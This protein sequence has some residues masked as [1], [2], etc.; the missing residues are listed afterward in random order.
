MNN[1]H[2]VFVIQQP[3]KRDGEGGERPAF[4]F[5]A[6]EG[7]GKLI[8]LAPNGKQIL[9]PDVF[10]DYL[11]GRLRA[12]AF[13]PKTDYIIPAGDYSVILMVG[14]II[15]EMFGRARILRWVPSAS[16]YQ[17]LHFNIRS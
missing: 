13:D 15:G 6:A 5:T 1:K 14:M 11:V 4:D 2:R 16:A 7:F 9:T 8:V 3:M 17:P 12:D 10:R